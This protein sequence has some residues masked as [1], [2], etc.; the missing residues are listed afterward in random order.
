LRN[1]FADY[2]LF[3][4]ARIVVM[5]VLTTVAGFY[6]G[7]R[8]SMDMTLLM[9]TMIGTGLVV[10]SANAL[11]QVIER[12]L[13]ARMERT[14]NRPI[15]AGRMT[16]REG[17]LSGLAMAAVGLVILVMKVNMLTAAIGLLSWLNYLFLYTPLKTRTSWS[18]S[19]GAISGALPPVMGWAAVR[20][21]LS[22]EALAL[23]LILFLW[24]LPHFLAIAWLYKEDYARGG[25]PFVPVRD[26]DGRRTAWQVV[27][28]CSMLVPIS[29][30][31]AFLGVAGNVYLVGALLLAA[32]FLAFGIRMARHVSAP[33]A[34]QL[35]YVSLLFLPMLLTLLVVDKQVL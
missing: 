22:L 19:I 31:P 35:L 16:V 9:W 20:N 1:L 33:Y 21:S 25:F 3:T 8:G 26:S 34:R 14:R 28:Y 17:W 10:S 30:I 15:P 27:L 4:K 32:G 5:V 13:D 29:L 7:A 23:F 18:T 24:Q 6:L 2:F 11:N 12:D